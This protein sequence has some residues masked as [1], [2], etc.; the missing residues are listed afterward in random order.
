M[1]KRV[2]PRTPGVNAKHVI[3]VKV[4]EATKTILENQADRL[5]VSQSEVVRRAIREYTGGDTVE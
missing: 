5:G 4:D 2:G 1:T 3:T